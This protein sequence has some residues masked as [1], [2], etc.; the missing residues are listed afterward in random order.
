MNILISRA[1]KQGIS[2]L[3]NC[4]NAWEHLFE[5][6]VSIEGYK[7]ETDLFLQWDPVML[8]WWSTFLL[9]H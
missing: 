1:T 9:N 2:T 3:L 4:S 5:F 8:W 6:Q 7:V